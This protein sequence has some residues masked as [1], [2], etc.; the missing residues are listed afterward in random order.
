MRTTVD[1]LTALLRKLPIFPA[2]VEIAI[3]VLTSQPSHAIQNVTLTR[4][5]LRSLRL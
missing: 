4:E 5:L 2:Q 3:R 1:A